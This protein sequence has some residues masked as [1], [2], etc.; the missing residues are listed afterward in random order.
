V[1]KGFSLIELIFVIAI[2]GI[3]SSIGAEVLIKSTEA[4]LLQRTKQASSEKAELAVEQIAN[5]LSYRMDISLRGKKLDGTSIPLSDIDPLLADKEEYIGL[6]WIGYDN[7]SFASSAVPGWSGF[8]D[9][10]PSVTNYNSI[11][12]TGSN[13]NFAKKVMS[14][15]TG[16]NNNA[17]IIFT[18]TPNYKNSGGTDYSY[19]TNCLYQSN[20][21][22]FPVNLS[23]D[24]LTFTGGDRTSGEMIYSEYYQLASSAYTLMPEENGD[25]FDLFL[26]Y[27]YQPWL[28]EN[29]KNGTKV[30]IA[31][32]ITVFRFTQQNKTIRIK[33]CI[34]Q[35]LR[36]KELVT[37]REKAVIR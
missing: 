6:E 25:S 5:R 32:N 20:G 23:G 17:A 15:K 34:K 24:K 36:K 8:V 35:K 28:G 14:E 27:N 26:Y 29:Y 31:N 21:C 37:C 11:T 13:L 12:S 22:I 7:D 2:L 4:Y 18:D 30:L 9:L 10:D 1:K 19:T 33:T 16:S 3:V